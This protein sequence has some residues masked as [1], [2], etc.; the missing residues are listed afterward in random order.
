MPGRL[1]TSFR[2]GNLAEQLGLLLLKGIAAVA[3]VPRTEDVGLDAVATLLRRAPD[4][5]CY[6]EDG[7][8]VQLK[9][10]SATSIEYRDHELS[11][12][13][14]VRAVAQATADD[15]IVSPYAAGLRARKLG[16]ITPAEY[17]PNF[18]ILF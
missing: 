1:R 3:D 7:F 2:S 4:G 18:P 17:R 9:S 16:L 13:R 10:Y 8:V 15:F 12:D 6:A 5:N 14:S 11:C